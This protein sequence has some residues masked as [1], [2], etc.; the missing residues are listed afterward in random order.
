[1]TLERR[2]SLG[3]DDDLELLHQPAE[4]VHVGDARHRAQQRAHDVILH[5]AQ[6]GRV[7]F[8]VLADERVLENF[9]EA[10]GD[11]A[12]L[13]IDARGQTFPRAWQPLG[14]KLPREVVVHAVLEDDGD[15]AKA[16]LRHG[17]DFRRAAA[18]RPSAFRWDA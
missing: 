6:F 7:V 10:R 5:R 11:R 15:R 9:A 18:A 14:D 3:F 13:D 16:D 1:M 12:E 2:E 4:R 8:R 17:A